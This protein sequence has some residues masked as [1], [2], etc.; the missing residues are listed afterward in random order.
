MEINISPQKKKVNKT[1]L[2]VAY[3]KPFLFYLPRKE[4]GF[5]PHQREKGKD[6]YF[7][8]PQKIRPT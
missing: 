2:F 7:L 1:I 5:F 4:E 8:L 6:K 3:T